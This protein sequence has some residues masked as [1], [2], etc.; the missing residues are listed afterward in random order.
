MKTTVFAAGVIVSLPIVYLQAAHAESNGVFSLETGMDYNTGKYGGTQSTNILYVPV[1]GK[2]QSKSWSLKLTVPY[3]RIT[4]PG[5]V[6]NVIN[7]FAVTGTTS[8]PV[9]RSGMGDVV[10]AVT[11]NAYNGGVSGL[12]VNLTGKVKFGTASVAKGLG[13][14]ANDYAFQADLFE[15]IG[16]FTPFGTFGYKVYG[17]PP[18]FT[19]NN[20]FY[21][22][23]GSSYK[24]TPE[25]SGGALLTYS[26]KITAK[27]APHEQ[28]LLFVTRRVEK[29]WKVQGYA[30]KGFTKSVPDWGIGA[31]VGYQF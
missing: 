6:I 13:T 31:T 23:L 12:K 7:G 22:L 15:S 21:G 25:T 30:L 2:Y 18:G 19:L 17:S 5:N 29:Y 8:A 3:L 4:G 11:G 20:A 10:A 26:Q 24:F 14:G 28:A 16:K 1:T 9:T 27:G